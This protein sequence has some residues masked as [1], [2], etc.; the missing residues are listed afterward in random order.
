MSSIYID[1]SDYMKRSQRDRQSHFNL[2]ENCIEIG[3]DSREYRGLLAFYL[4]T[5]IPKGMKVHLCH[6][7]HNARCSNPRHLYWGSPKENLKDALDSGRSIP[8]HVRRKN[9]PNGMLGKH[10]SEKT[11]EKLRNNYK[12][13]KQ[14]VIGGVWPSPPSLEDGDPVFESQITD[15]S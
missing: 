8:I 4:K 11:K 3:G 10:H 5:T 13:K 1:I 7:C 2:T 9:L 6:A 15:H 14:T 12:L